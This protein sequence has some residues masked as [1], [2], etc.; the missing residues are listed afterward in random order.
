M[1]HYHCIFWIEDAPVI[2]IDTDETILEYIGKHIS[3]KMPSPDED[4]ILHNL[5]K[6]YQY[7]RCNSYCLRSSK[8]RGKAVCKFS[9]PRNST[10][11][12]VLHSV[13]SSIVS[14]QSRSYQRR[15]Y[16]L[17]RKQSE[18]RINDYSFPDDIEV[19]QEAKDFIK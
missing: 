16:E 3:C 17:E 1:P 12:P 10:Q 9:F 6:R 5:V 19:Q 11:K 18:I 8:A 14:K 15:L 4:P 13:L 2:G 7:H